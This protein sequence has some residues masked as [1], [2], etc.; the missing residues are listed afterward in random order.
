MIKNNI[1]YFALIFISQL[2]EANYLDKKLVSNKPE[3]AAMVKV[4]QFINSDN[5]DEKMQEVI[6]KE[7]YKLPIKINETLTLISNKFNIDEKKFYYYYKFNN[8]NKI[9]DKDIE[10]RL[11]NTLCYN[12]FY[13]DIMKNGYS[14]YYRYKIINEKNR[15]LNVKIDYSKCKRY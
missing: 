14:Y 12:M 3:I 6:K 10:K 5:F 8:I 15:I 4:K 7:H 11:I 2:L 13:K 1:K 9:K